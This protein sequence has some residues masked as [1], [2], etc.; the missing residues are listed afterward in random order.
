MLD[1]S[2]HDAQIRQLYT[3]GTPSLDIARQLDIDLIDVVGR[4]RAME[5]QPP[6][7]GV[8]RARPTPCSADPAPMTVAQAMPTSMAA[9]IAAPQ[10]RRFAAPP[11]AAAPVRP[12]ALSP[13]AVARPVPAGRGLPPSTALADEDEEDELR[14]V[15]GRPRGWLMSEAEAEALFARSGGRFQDVILRKRP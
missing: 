3:T 6:G 12:A 5:L 4:V 10:P 2:H 15:P 1:L 7:M 13:L 11:R 14:I 8:R 9:T